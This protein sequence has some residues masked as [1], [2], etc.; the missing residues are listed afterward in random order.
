M[1]AWL[2]SHMAATWAPKNCSGACVR[3]YVCALLSLSQFL[4]GL[5]DPRLGSTRT[6]LQPAPQAFLGNTSDA[7]REVT[8]MRH[9]FLGFAQQVSVALLF[10]AFLAG[11]PGLVSGLSGRCLYIRTMYNGEE[12]GWD[13]ASI[14]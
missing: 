9:T 10:G 4:R 12:S 11:L 8:H 3:A 13:Y 5:N 2:P 7:A 6:T 14:K 1:E